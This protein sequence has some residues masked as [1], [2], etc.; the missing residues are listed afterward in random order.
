MSCPTPHVNQF[1]EKRLQF[2]VKGCGWTFPLRY[3]LSIEDCSFEQEWKLKADRL[4]ASA[5][6]RG[7][8]CLPLEDM[9]ITM[10]DG[11][12][13]RDSYWKKQTFPHFF[14]SFTLSTFQ[15]NQSWLMTNQ[16]FNRCWSL[17]NHIWSRSINNVWCKA[18]FSF[19]RSWHA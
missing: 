8:T 18:I 19:I 14:N 12:K 11:C 13:A 2:K 6:G 4:T 17:V 15:V 10:I 5:R 7:E 3:K 16:R 1:N 9:Q